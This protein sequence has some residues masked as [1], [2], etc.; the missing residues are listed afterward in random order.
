MNPRLR[1]DLA[2]VALGAGLVNAALL[3]RADDRP[4]S[5]AYLLITVVGVSWSFV[6]AGLVAWTRRP[7]NRTGALMLAVGLSYAARQSRSRSGTSCG[8]CQKAFSLTC[9]PCSRTAGPR[10]GCNEFSSSPTMQ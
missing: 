1:L 5:L 9:S 6:G 2:F 3:V 8:P 10:P 4:R 7:T